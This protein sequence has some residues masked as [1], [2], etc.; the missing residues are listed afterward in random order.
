VSLSG[1]LVSRQLLYFQI[2]IPQMEG[3]LSVD[4]LL[5]SISVTAIVIGPNTFKFS[6]NLQWSWLR[7]NFL[8][9][10]LNVL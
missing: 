8:L 1:D 2:R 6:S 7:V 4:L 9:V 10:F 3:S 5:G